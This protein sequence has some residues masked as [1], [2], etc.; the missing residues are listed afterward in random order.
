MDFVAQVEHIKMAFLNQTDLFR[1]FSRES[2]KREREEKT[3]H[4]V[5]KG[6]FGSA[7]FVIWLCTQDFVKTN[8]NICRWH[9]TSDRNVPRQLLNTPNVN[10][11]RKKMSEMM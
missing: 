10:W 9:R 8:V 11:R 6:Q 5:Q 7:R 2:D 3:A 4:L 1:L